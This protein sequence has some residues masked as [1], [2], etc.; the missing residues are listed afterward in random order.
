MDIPLTLALVLAFGPA[1]RCLLSSHPH[2]RPHRPQEPRPRPAV[3][4]ALLF[5]LRASVAGLLFI[6]LNLLYL[7]VR[8]ASRSAL[9]TVPHTSIVCTR[10]IG[11]DA[12]LSL[13][14]KTEGCVLGSELQAPLVG[15]LDECV[16]KEYVSFCNATV[17][18]QTCVRMDEVR[19]NVFVIVVPSIVDSVR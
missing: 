14:P 6:L 11:G 7:P 17:I 3:A 2:R 9:L 10:V 18:G 4:V 8:I 13:C 1:V 19:P 15:L 16:R 5:I 12:V